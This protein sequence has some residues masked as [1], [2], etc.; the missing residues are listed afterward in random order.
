MSSTARLKF[1]M[2]SRNRHVTSSMHAGCCEEFL[3]TVTVNCCGCWHQVCLECVPRTCTLASPSPHSTISIWT[4]ES[5]RLTGFDVRVGALPFESFDSRGAGFAT[6]LFALTQVSRPSLGG[7]VAFVV[8]ANSSTSRVIRRQSVRGIGV[9]R[10][11][12]QSSC[13]RARLP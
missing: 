8:D 4:R 11:V 10:V 5:P 1:R 9:L 6:P 2:A 13:G 3:G 12:T 7:T